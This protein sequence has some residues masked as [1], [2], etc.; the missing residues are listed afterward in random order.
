M[1][2]QTI[3]EAHRNVVRHWLKFTQD[4]RATLMRGDFRPHQ[5]QAGFPVVEAE[6]ADERIIAVYVAGTA[7]V[8]GSLDKPVYIINATGGGSL[9]VELPAAAKVEYYDTFGVRAGSAAV[10]AGLH[11]LDVPASGY[12]LVTR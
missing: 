7:A 12:A 6:S 11:R 4:H 8:S 9:V 10:G 5:P 1:V 2:L 3:P